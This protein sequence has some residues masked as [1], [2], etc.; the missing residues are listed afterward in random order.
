MCE[1]VDNW[2]KIQLLLNR[3]WSKE[4]TEYSPVCFNRALMMPKS[5]RSKV[6]EILDTPYLLQKGVCRL[7][8]WFDS[9]AQRISTQTAEE[10]GV[11]KNALLEWQKV[12]KAIR[13]ARIRLTN[14]RNR[15]T[16]SDLPFN[17]FLCRSEK[18]YGK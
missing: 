2:Q 9:R 7:G 6:K 10:K 17:P 18:C 13:M 8:L 3:K 15:D 1:L 14:V 12:S 16:Y 5:N 4:I 11:P